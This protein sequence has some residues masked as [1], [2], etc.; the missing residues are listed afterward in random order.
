[1]R[2]LQTAVC[3]L[4]VALSAMAFA[5]DERKAVFDL[6]T[7]DAKRIETHV[8]GA[9]KDLSDYYA[10][11][12][13]DFKAV[14]VISGDAYKF[15]IDDLE[16]SPYKDDTDLK[17][18]RAKLKPMLE[19]LHVKYGVRFDLCGQGMKMRNIHPDTVFPF[20]NTDK[21]KYVY[22]INWQNAGYAYIPV[23]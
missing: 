10:K 12:G 8:I 18:V 9:I 4:L 1:M 15:F 16:R 20:V 7:G 3:F 5:A 13:S 11:E 6:T 21:S 14:V 2:L 23:S 19:E 22:L 17:A